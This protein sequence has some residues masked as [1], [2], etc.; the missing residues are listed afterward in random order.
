MDINNIQ[1]PSDLGR[2]VPQNINKG[3]NN[4]VNG[5][6]AADSDAVEISAE[7]HEVAKLVN[8]DKSELLEF[9]KKSTGDVRESKIQDVKGK[10]ESGF[11][12]TPEAVDNL[13][14]KLIDI[15]S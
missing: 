1:R 7:A 11:F 5:D 3:T 2:V 10:L 15:V 13:V 8:G 14:G 12:D 9:A 6:F 4:G